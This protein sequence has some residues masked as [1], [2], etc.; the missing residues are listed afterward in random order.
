MKFR[1]VVNAV[2]IVATMVSGICGVLCSGEK[3]VE[4]VKHQ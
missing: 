4:I 2:A 1:K 3:L